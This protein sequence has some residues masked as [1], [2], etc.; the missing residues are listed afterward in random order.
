MNKP[1]LKMHEYSFV[2]FILLDIVIIYFSN[3]IPFPHFPY[4]PNPH[5]IFPPPA[6]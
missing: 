6:H 5:T 4:N 1:I 3:I 2:F